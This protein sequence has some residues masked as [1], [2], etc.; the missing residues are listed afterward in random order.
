MSVS[1]DLL[2]RSLLGLGASRQKVGAVISRVASVGVESGRTD[3]LSG[4]VGIEAPGFD[5][6][7]LSARG[8]AS[9]PLSICDVAPDPEPSG[10]SCPRVRE[11]ESMTVTY[12][13][14]RRDLLAFNFYFLTHGRW[15]LRFGTVFLVVTSLINVT[16]LDGA[17]SASENAAT[18]AVLEAMA[19]LIAAVVLVLIVLVS[20]AFMSGTGLFCERTITVTEESLTE[21]TAVNTQLIRWPGVAKVVR[22]GHQ[23]LVFVGPAAAHVIPRRAVR[24]QEEWDLLY[25][26]IVDAYRAAH[27]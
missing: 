2:V 17:R 14:T 7:V 12:T 22:A 4:P 13:N 16:T 3:H 5:D 24:S 10:S 9:R 1:I 18:F 6:Q 19:L 26:S 20:V 21:S 15:M 25:K 8:Q 27:A 11:R 23:I